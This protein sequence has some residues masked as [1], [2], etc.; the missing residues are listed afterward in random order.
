MTQP[1]RQ[2]SFVKGLRQLIY[3][4]ASEMDI[5][6]LDKPLVYQQSKLHCTAAPSHNLTVQDDMDEVQQERQVALSD[7]A[8]TRKKLRDH[9]QQA[10]VTLQGRDLKIA[11]A[12]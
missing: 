5:I 11:A 12:R 7:A 1:L 9:Q 3:K 8:A 6:N 4:A 2:G 10:A